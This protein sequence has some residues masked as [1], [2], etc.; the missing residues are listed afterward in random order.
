MDDVARDH[1]SGAALDALVAAVVL[2]VAMLPI[3]RWRA[4]PDWVRLVL[5]GIAVAA[6]L[7]LVARTHLADVI[8]ARAVLSRMAVPA[9]LTAWVVVILG[10]WLR[11]Q[12]QIDRVYD[13]VIVMDDR[14]IASIATKP[15]HGESAV[16]ATKM[17]MAIAPPQDR[18]AAQEK[19]DQEIA[20]LRFA[21]DL[22]SA[23]SG[24]MADRW[25]SSTKDER[26]RSTSLSGSI[27]DLA[28]RIEAVRG[29][30]VGLRN[31][32]HGD[33]VKL[34]KEIAEHDETIGKLW[35]LTPP[36]TR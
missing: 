10:A 21:I 1:F 29:E 25:V 8:A 31:L 16:I 4:L 20:K 7:F 12:K 33:L 6:A 22:L 28:K 2:G 3:K 32:D 17:T 26:E 19:T 13:D 34:E 30:L 11:I 18:L 23:E 36:G 14:L 5:S 15:D 24:K 35:R 27:S 9:A